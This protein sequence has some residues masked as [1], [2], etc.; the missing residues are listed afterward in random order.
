MR[1]DV[2]EVHGVP[3]HLDLPVRPP[4]ENERPVSRADCEVTSAIDPQPAWS[5]R[6]FK[7]GIDQFLTREFLHAHITVKELRP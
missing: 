6:H 4:L 2:S 3:S 7:L 5:A 1:V